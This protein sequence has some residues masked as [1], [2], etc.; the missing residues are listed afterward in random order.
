VTVTDTDPITFTAWPKISHLYRPVLIT[1]KIDGTNAAIGVK[2]DGRVYAQSRKRVITPEQDNHGFA[3]FVAEN[4]DEIREL[5][6]EGLH[7]GEWYGPG[8]GKRYSLSGK[9][10]K[11][12]ALFNVKRWANEPLPTGITTVPLLYDRTF[13]DSIV[14]LCLDDLRNQGS[15][16]GASRAEGLIVYFTQSNTSFKVTLE[17]DEMSKGE[18][19]R[20]AEVPLADGRDPGTGLSLQLVA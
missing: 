8:I 17:N 6:G 19:L 2:P 10:L 15:R 11:Q 1:E 13:D 3:R 9:Q 5:L 20:R 18:A 16:S 14:Q 7:F 12:F 4:E